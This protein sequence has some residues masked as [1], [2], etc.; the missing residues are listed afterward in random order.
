[1]LLENI[2]PAAPGAIIVGSAIAIVL[3]FAVFLRAMPQRLRP[4][5]LRT[6]HTSPTV[7]AGAGPAGSHVSFL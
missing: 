4:A 2:F 3:I 6:E 7:L 1:M 5:V